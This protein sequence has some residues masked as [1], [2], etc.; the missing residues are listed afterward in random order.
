MGRA[1]LRSE[2][3]PSGGPDGTGEVAGQRFQHV[4]IGNPQCAIRVAGSNSS[5]RSTCPRLAR[6]SSATPQF[7]NRTNVSLVVCDG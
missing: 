1:R 7:P 4:A 5:P 2:H 3:F 6:R